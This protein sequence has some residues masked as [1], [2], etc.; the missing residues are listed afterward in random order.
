[1]NLYF[2]VFGSGRAWLL[3]LILLLSL[4]GG[5]AAA[6]S[7][8]VGFDEEAIA[9]REASGAANEFRDLISDL[10]DV[11]VAL[12]AQGALFSTRTA[13][14]DE[15]LERARREIPADGR[16]VVTVG[17]DRSVLVS[18][19]PEALRESRPDLQKAIPDLMAKVAAFGGGRSVPTVRPDGRLEIPIDASLDVRGL[20]ASLMNSVGLQLRPV[21]CA[22]RGGIAHAPACPGAEGPFATAPGDMLYVRREAVLTADMIGRW[23]VLTTSGPVTAIEAP[24]TPEGRRRLAEYSRSHAGSRQAFIFRGQVLAAPKLLA[25]IDG[26]SIMI[27][28]VSND[29]TTRELVAALNEYAPPVALVIF[30]SPVP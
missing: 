28:P 25:P 2:P 7:L 17:S 5:S 15:L 21:E 29:E 3:S 20:K 26:A 4:P 18:Y 6:A 11:D 30:E 10:P 8:I 16:L 14:R 27:N 13:H 12:T 24:L 9:L 23:R 22:V 1:M 19:S